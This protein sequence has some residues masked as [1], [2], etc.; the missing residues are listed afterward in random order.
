MMRERTF[1]PTGERLP[2]IGQG[3]WN[4]EHADRRDA[5]RALQRGF[6]LGLTHVDTAEMYGHGA[7]E[8]A[9]QPVVGLGLLGARLEHSFEEDARLFEVAGLEVTDSC[10]Q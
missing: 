8:G 1:G 4:L 2:P 5:V 10:L 7:A 9:A 6:E 3:T